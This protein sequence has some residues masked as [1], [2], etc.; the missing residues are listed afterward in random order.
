MN[1][2][3][4]FAIF[5]RLV[6]V[7]PCL[8]ALGANAGA[9]GERGDFWLDATLRFHLADTPHAALPAKPDPA[10]RADY[11]NKTT[12]DSSVVAT[13][14]LGSNKR[15][16]LLTPGP[17]VPFW[18]L[19]ADWVFRF[20]LTHVGK[21]NPSKLDFTMIDV[22][23][24]TAFGSFAIRPSSESWQL[25][26]ITIG[27]LEQTANF[28]FRRVARLSLG[29]SPVQP[30]RVW[31][32]GV[33]FF[34]PDNE[35]ALTDQLTLQRMA[36][37]IKTRKARIDGLFQKLST[38]MPD[39]TK[40]GVE[41]YS[42]SQLRRET[43]KPDLQTLFANLLLNRNVGET[44][45]DLLRIYGPTDKKLRAHYGLEYT[46]HLNATP[47]LYRFYLNFGSQSKRYPGRLSPEV[48]NVILELLW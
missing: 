47:M 21:S 35:I 41:Y 11:A 39:A 4:F 33:R 6:R 46:W 5:H 30:E 18:T 25:V 7:A 29:F 14:A 10:F 19:E 9:G 22:S 44:N 12:G 37:E 16:L 24:N 45:R 3:A 17:Y 2:P 34:G 31:L 27:K 13:F 42:A 28:D 20:E 40:P 15:L 36:E 23:G 48:E 38:P 26:E 8:I 1:I 43:D 32:D